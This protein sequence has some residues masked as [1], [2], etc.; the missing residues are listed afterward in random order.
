VNGSNDN[1]S[2]DLE[3]RIAL[4]KKEALEDATARIDADIVERAKDLYNARKMREDQEYKIKL[5]NIIAE[6][7]KEENKL[8]SLA[9]EFIDRIRKELRNKIEIRLKCEDDERRRIEEE[10]KRQKEETDLKRAEEERRRLEEETR[11][12]EEERQKRAAE[13]QL[14]NEEENRQRELIAKQREEEKKAKDVEKNA[15]IRALITN[16]NEYI[17]AGDFEHARV[18]IAKALV[19]DPNNADALEIE[20]RIKPAK[21]ESA[22]I[23]DEE[24]GEKPKQSAKER[25]YTGQAQHS[26]KKRISTKLLVSIIS[27]VAVITIIVFFQMKKYVFTLP[28]KVAVMPWINEAN[29]LEENVLGIALAEEVSNKFSSVSSAP[30][31]GFSSTYQLVQKTSLPDREAFRLGF[32]YALKGNFHRVGSNF[33]LELQL[34]DSLGKVAWS[35]KFPTPPSGLSLLPSEITKQIAEVLELPVPTDESNKKIQN[36]SKNPDSYLFYLRCREMLHRRTP[37]SLKNAYDLILQSIQDD[38]KFAEGLALASDI[39]ALQLED[40]VISGDSIIVRGKNLADAAIEANPQLDM[41]YI[42]LGKILAFDKNYNRALIKLDTALF[43]TPFNSSAWFEKGKILLKL[44]RTQD[45]L[46]ALNRAYQLDACNPEILQ[47]CGN[48]YQITGKPKLAMAFHDNAVKFALDSLVYLSG[49]VSDAILVDPELRLS[50]S[51]RILAACEKRIVMNQNDYHS[52]YN[53]ARLKQVM[54]HLD[55]DKLLKKLETM[56]QEIIR[57]S[58]KDARAVAYLA[59]AETR[60]G[61]FPEAVSIAQRAMTIDPYDA[62]VKFKVAEMYSLQMYSQKEKQFDEKK[63]TEAARYLREAISLNFKIDEVVNADFFN[64][65]E[66]PEYKSAIQERAR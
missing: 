24:P 52:L 48:A 57:K 23:S 10:A 15:R 42:S 53:F 33:L 47:I 3:Q 7:D 26:D 54:G 36:T 30:V 27:V 51:Q 56:L 19:N 20:A 4:A 45:A 38:P 60:L 63:K 29:T 12:Q 16:A 35:T 55:S 14:R 1:V 44:G 28:L 59:L 22:T 50:Q 31:M 2:K 58:P 49:P 18:E 40:G 46:D 25:K 21:I 13:E 41:G 9:D 39:L 64:M 8:R 11:K 37:E 32:T 17:K 62:E 65:F 66:R 34:A 5:Q 61:R 43:L 6:R